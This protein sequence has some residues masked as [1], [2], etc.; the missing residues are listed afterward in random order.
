MKKAGYTAVAAGL[1][2]ESLRRKGMIEFFD[3]F[4]EGQS[5]KACRLTEKGLEWFLANQDKFHMTKAEAAAAAR[6]KEEEDIPF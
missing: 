5:L 2:M 3:N 1:G 4:N 6:A